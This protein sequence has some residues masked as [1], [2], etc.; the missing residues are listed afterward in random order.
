MIDR[1]KQIGAQQLGQLPRIDAVI[2]IAF[3]QQSVAARIAHHDICDVRLEQ[4]IQPSR[5]GAF[6]KCQVQV[7]T[8][9]ADELQKISSGASDDIGSD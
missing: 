1:A 6:L 5:P 8:Q 7:P 9:S 2:L 3:L 4:V